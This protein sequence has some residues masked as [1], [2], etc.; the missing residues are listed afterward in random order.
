MMKWRLWQPG[1][2]ERQ[3][4]G[5]SPLLASWEK[6]THPAQIRLRAYLDDIVCKLK[7][8]SEDGPLYLQLEVDV[9]N[10][11][12]L[13]R[14]YDLENYLTPPFGSRC[15]PSA[16]FP[17]VVARKHVGG[18]SRI[19]WRRALPALSVDED[20]WTSFTINAGPGATH[21]S[22]KERIRHAL[23]LTGPRP[24]RYL[25]Q[26][27]TIRGEQLSDDW[28]SPVVVAGDEYAAVSAG[29]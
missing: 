28:Q 2:I 10:P 25:V 26:V 21:K 12:R 11:Q 24:G 18:G 7:P 4:D 5:I 29:Q 16:R 22:W 27:M 19:A 13:L 23:E 14:H 3:I 15:L 1:P 17:F 8:L 9:Q 6:T 20:G